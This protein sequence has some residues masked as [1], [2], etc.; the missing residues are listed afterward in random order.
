MRL[1]IGWDC[2]WGLVYTRLVDGCAFARGV[3]AMGAS[4]RARESDGCATAGACCEVVGAT[5]GGLV[6]PVA[7]SALR[8][9]LEPCRTVSPLDPCALTDM[10][11]ARE[12]VQQGSVPVGV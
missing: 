1:A 7:T 12:G 11:S 3:P 9:T 2:S 6:G 5:G 4:A 10:L 8:Q